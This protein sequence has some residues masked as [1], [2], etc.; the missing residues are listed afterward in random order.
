MDHS[1]N[2]S[3]IHFKSLEE[4]LETLVEA[5]NTKNP[6][7]LEIDGIIKR[8]EYTFEQSWKMIR[9]L[10]IHMG[11]DQVSSSPRPLLRDAHEENLISDIKAWFAFLEARNRTSHQYNEVESRKIYEQIKDFPPLAKSLLDELNKKI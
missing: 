8:F 10:L 7:E 5:L 4:A 9:K 2:N 6:S 1:K 3:S 11:R